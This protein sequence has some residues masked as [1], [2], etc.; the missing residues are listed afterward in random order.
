MAFA[1]PQSITVNAVPVSLPRTSVERNSSEYVSADGRRKLKISHTYGKVNR[2]V[3]RSDAS[4]IVADPI[5]G[6]NKISSM[7]VYV[8]A[9]VPSDGTYSNT[10]AKYEVDAL[11][12]ELTESSG[13]NVVKWL[14]GES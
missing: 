14:G 6:I 3:Y 2:R 9:V 11:V 10:E 12:A 7:S 1:D 8:V 5:T 4:K 13:A